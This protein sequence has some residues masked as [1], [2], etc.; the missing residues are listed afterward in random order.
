[1]KKIACLLA[2]FILIL[3]SCMEKSNESSDFSNA[4]D[5]FI[6]NYTTEYARVYTSSAEA[7]WIA[8]IEIKPGDS[9]NDIAS[10]KAQQQYSDF[11][12]KKIIIDSVQYFLKGRKDLSELQ[13]RQLEAIL[14]RAG[15]NPE[16][17]AEL[18]TKRIKTET[19]A[20]SK[21]YGFTFR[22]NGKPV[23]TNDIDGILINETNL[24]KRL[25][26]WQASK[27]V[28]KLLKN[29]LVELRTLRNQSV[30]PL[31]YKDFFAYQVAEYGMSTDEMLQLNEG[32]VETIWPLYREIHT[33]FRYE[34]AKK[35][36]EAVPEYLPAHWLPNRW[37][38][39]WTGL[40]QVKGADLDSALQKLS[41]VD[42]VTRGEKFYRSLGY[43]ALPNVF[44]NKSNLYPYPPDSVVKKN[45]HASAWH[46][47]LG[48]D[49]RS[50]MSVTPNA[51]W[52]KTAH[53]ELGHI[54]YFQAYS[55]SDVPLTLRGGANRG[56]HEAIG[57]LI[58]LASTHLP[59]LQSQGLVA[60]EAKEDTM[61]KLFKESLYYIVHLP[62]SAGVMTHFEKDLYAD[63]LA[64]DQFNSRW[65]SLVK[66]YQG[67]VPAS[68][69][70]EEYCDAATKTHIIDDPAQYYD[71]A[72][73]FCLL[74]QMH[75]HI[76]NKIL[77]QDPHATNYFGS[78]STGDFL[79]NIMKWGQSR[80]WRQV[81]K[82]ST[83][84]TL[85]AN[86]M[87]EYFKPLLEWLKKQNMGRTY[88]LPENIK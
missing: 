41:A 69:R 60:G 56:Y 28:G 11:I 80:D 6:K 2:T 21:L 5:L 10:Q 32:F 13:L 45:T 84:D 16:I 40:L 73:S 63:N 4:A 51:Y 72:V 25:A 42:V 47:D 23:S 68:P 81:L 83:G 54:Y 75:N 70:S 7:Q 55:Q 30:Q 57:D 66:K 43:E 78:K 24:Q 19:E 85:N 29:D 15:G 33:Y 48:N 52:W 8:N 77:H 31:G 65:W 36:H 62:W 39:D 88:S 74:M 34:L 86:A 64:P 58:G 38:Q 26:G 1:M 18:I 61:Q 49:V 35:Y 53:H 44:W 46:M 3:S 9:T 76:A 22:I 79:K 71:Y 14:Y 17:V 12:G 87:M 37:G 67:I 20:T 27:E 82:E 50:L 59:Y